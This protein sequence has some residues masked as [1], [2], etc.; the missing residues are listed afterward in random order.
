MTLHLVAQPWL[1]TVCVVLFLDVDIEPSPNQNIITL[2]IICKTYHI[3]AELKLTPLV[4]DAYWVTSES[5]DL[6]GSD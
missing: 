2:G 4:Q 1:D 3:F 5:W 6:R